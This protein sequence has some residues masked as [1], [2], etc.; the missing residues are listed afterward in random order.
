MRASGFSA[1]TT[2][3]VFALA[4]PAIAQSSAATTTAQKSERYD[5]K[6]ITLTGC[7]EKNKSGGHFLTHASMSPDESAAAGTSTTTG[8][9]STTGTTGST[10]TTTTTAPSTASATTW[11]LENGKDLDRYVNQKVEVIGHP[12]KSSSGDEV[13]G[14]TGPEVQARDLDVLSVKVI[15]SSCR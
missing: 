8:T 3:A 12:E 2:A 7:I 5:S 6:Q 13:K 11:N 4:V 1:F 9:T 15:S 14:T 10:A